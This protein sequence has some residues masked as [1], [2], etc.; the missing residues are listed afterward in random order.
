[1]IP[2]EFVYSRISGWLWDEELGGKEEKSSGILALPNAYSRHG[3]RLERLALTVPL[4]DWELA[5]LDN[6]FRRYAPG[7]TP[8]VRRK[9]LLKADSLE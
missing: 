1:M 9:A 4:K 5:H 6:E 7:D 8:T 3:A 2:R